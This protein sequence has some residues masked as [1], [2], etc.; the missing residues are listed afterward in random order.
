M[1][2]RYGV[3]EGSSLADWPLTYDDL[4]RHYTRAEQ[5]FGVCRD[6]QAHRCQGFRSREYPMPAQ[7]STREADVLRKGAEALRLSTGPVP[8]LLNSRPRDGRAACVRCGEC[9]G[10]GCPVDAR[11]GA[12]NTVILLALKTGLCRLVSGH[13]AQRVLVDGTGRATGAVV[14]DM[15]TGARVEVRAGAVVLAAGAIETARLLLAS[16]TDK[17]PEGLGNRSGQVGRH[18]Q[19]H[20]Y[21]GAFGSFEEPVQDLQGPGVSIATCDYMHDLGGDVVGGGVLANE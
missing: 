11:A 7:P 20:N 10:F 1:A 2:S 12:H 17:A 15:D 9:V 14:R 6:G 3:P 13:R 16:A 18:L 8:L 4:E 19:G 21:T 5:E